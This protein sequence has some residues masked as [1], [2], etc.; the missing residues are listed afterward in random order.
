MKSHTTAVDP[1]IDETPE[2]S[3]SLHPGGQTT[4]NVMTRDAGRGRDCTQA[5]VIQQASMPSAQS[6]APAITLVEAPLSAAERY[7]ADVYRRSSAGELK[8]GHKA[9]VQ[10]FHDEVINW[11]NPALASEV[12]AAGFVDH[13]PYLFPGQPVTGP[14]ALAWVVSSFRTGFPDL[15]ASVED[16]VVAG[17][18]VCVR[19]I[20]TGRHGGEFLGIVPTGRRIKAQVIEMTRI[21]RG[22]VAEHWAEK[23]MLGMLKQLV[24]MSGPIGTMR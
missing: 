20:W 14:E 9:L 10:R 19:S 3:Q 2:Q 5:L 6:L 13:V 16:V 7:E 1:R 8:A 17:D 22:M 18:W 23:D 12:V 15:H 4:Q 11:G 21:A 24:P